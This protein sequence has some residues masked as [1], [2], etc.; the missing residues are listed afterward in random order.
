MSIEY[1]T[2]YNYY[3]FDF[4]TVSKKNKKN[5]IRTQKKSVFSL[6]LIDEWEDVRKLRQHTNIYCKWMS[7]YTRSQAV[8]AYA[9][10][11]Q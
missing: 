5:N 6:K 4:N 3:C 10:V 11:I 1:Y 9:Y 7:M 2:V 8:H